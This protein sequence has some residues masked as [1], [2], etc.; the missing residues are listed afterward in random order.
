[1]INY[2][3]CPIR[4]ERYHP[5]FSAEV[6]L[7]HQALA[8][9]RWS[10][11]HWIPATSVT[12]IPFTQHCSMFLN[13][14]NLIVSNICSYF[15]QVELLGFCQWG[16]R[17]MANWISGNIKWGFGKE[18]KQKLI[19]PPLNIIGRSEMNTSLFLPFFSLFFYFNK[20]NLY[21]Q[22]YPL[23]LDA[24]IL[25]FWLLSICHFVRLRKLKHITW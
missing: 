8:L 22:G 14:V 2:L 25:K 6:V 23:L 7:E 12:S 11:C 10:S 5:C 21:G 24:I 3:S 19:V 4:K 13:S 15:Y 18:V 9:Q 16:N 17:I 1:M 20:E